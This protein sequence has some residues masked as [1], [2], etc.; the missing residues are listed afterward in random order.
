MTSEFVFPSV[1]LGDPLGTRIVL[2]E[3]RKQDGC[4]VLRVEPKL[5]AEPEALLNRSTAVL[6]REALSLWIKHLDEAYVVVDGD[7][8][9]DDE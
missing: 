7:E 9:A 2:A 6:L 8:D 4:A 1:V 3:S 5:S